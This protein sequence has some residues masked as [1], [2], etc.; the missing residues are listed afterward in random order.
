MI[1]LIAL[2]ALLC[3]GVVTLSSTLGKARREGQRPDADPVD[4]V[5]ERLKQLDTENL[6]LKKRLAALES[7][8]ERITRGRGHGGSG[9]EGRKFRNFAWALEVL[10]LSV[11]NAKNQKMRRAAYRRA[12]MSAHPDQGGS[13]DRLQAV[14]SAW[15]ILNQEFGEEP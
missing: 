7:R 1:A 4:P 5:L 10:D 2:I 6:E 3:M 15:S 9:P 12:M 8:V 13:R 14:Q 11:D